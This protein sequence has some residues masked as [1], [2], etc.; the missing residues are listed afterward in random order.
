MNTLELLDK[1]APSKVNRSQVESIRDMYLKYS[2]TVNQ[3]R[4][5]EMFIFDPTKDQALNA[6]K[7][8][9]KAWLFMRHV[10]RY[11]EIVARISK[12]IELE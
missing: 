1:I 11:E 6:M 2:F 10:L 7:I 4:A 9:P 8:I 12:W 5:I 3:K